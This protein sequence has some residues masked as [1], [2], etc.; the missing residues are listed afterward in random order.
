VRLEGVYWAKA[1]SGNKTR[2]VARRKSRYLIMGAAL[3]NGDR[4]IIEQITGLR[5]RDEHL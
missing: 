4:V 3:V 1:I 5:S 2:V